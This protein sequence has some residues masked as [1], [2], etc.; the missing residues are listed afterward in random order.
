MKI[1]RKAIRSKYLGRDPG[2]LASI[3][4]PQALDHI[5]TG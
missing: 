1:V 3:E 4:N 2:D 5:P